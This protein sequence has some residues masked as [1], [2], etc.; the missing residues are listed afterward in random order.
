M[1]FYR[2]TRKED[3]KVMMKPSL[4]FQSQSSIEASQKLSLFMGGY[5]S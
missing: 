4:H 5:S 3:F 2:K 1:K